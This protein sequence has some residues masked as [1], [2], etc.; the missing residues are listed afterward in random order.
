MGKLKITGND[1]DV[2][3]AAC[4]KVMDANPG[5]HEQ[6][7]KEGLSEMRYRWDIL[8]KTGLK[9]GKSVGTPGDLNLYDYC[10]DDHIDSA[11]RQIT[12]TD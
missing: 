6:Y 3:A 8:W 11:L 7:R 5:M 10:N 2:L 12:G 1:Y 4:Q 9:I